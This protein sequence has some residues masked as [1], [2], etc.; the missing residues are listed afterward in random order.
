MEDLIFLEASLSAPM[1]SA[2]VELVVWLGV[3]FAAFILLLGL[4][5]R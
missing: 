2:E 3:A 1:T 5:R 4:V